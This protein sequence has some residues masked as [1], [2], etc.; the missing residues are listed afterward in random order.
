MSEKKEPKDGLSNVSQKELLTLMNSSEYAMFIAKSGS[1]MELIY[2]NDKF[3]SM[4]QYT[5]DEYIEK[6]GNSLMATVLDEE[7]Q[8]LR[9]LIARQAAAGGSLKLEYRAVRKDG[10]IAWLSLS[11]KA[12]V[13][14]NNFIYYSSCLD[15]TKSKKT[16]DDIYN[17]KREIDVMANSIPGGVIKV[18]MS[19]FKI[20]YAN[21]G[22]FILSG[23]SRSE[24]QMEFGGYY[25]SILY[26]ADIELVKKY[27]KLA[28][29]NH[30]LLGF[31]CR[32]SIKNGEVKWVYVNGR[33]ID[34]DNGQPVYL[35]ILTDITAKKNIEAEFNDNVKRAEVI[36]GF[37][38]AIIWT[39]DIAS[40][41]IKQ[42]GKLEPTYP[43]EHHMNNFN[44]VR[45]IMKMMHPNDIKKFKYNLK[46]LKEREWQTQEVYLIKNNT[47]VFQN[48]EIS[49]ISL[50]DG[51]PKP[52][53]I[54]GMIR[55]KNANETGANAAI[56]ETK[57]D[58]RLITLAK[59]SKSKAE[60]YITGLMPYSSFLTK[61]DKVLKCRNEKDQYAIVCA[62]IN[63]FLKF[64]HHYGFSVSNQIL[65]AFSK[66]IMGTIAKNGICSRVDGDYFVV[67]FKYNQHKELMKIMSSMVRAKEEFDKADG[68]VRFGTTTGIYL[69]QP[70]DDEL[71]DM[72]GKADLARRSIK[73]LMGDHY[74]IYTE[75][76][77][78]YKFKED[79][80]IDEI[81]NA[82][83]TRNIEICFI[84]RIY[85][86]KENI[87]GCK[88]IPRVLLKDGQYIESVR[89]LKF[90]ERGG[91]LNEF[92]FVTLFSVCANMGAW[93]M[94]GHKI[95][96]LSIEITASELSMQNA[97]DIIDEIVIRKNH[98][99]PNQIIF[100]IHERY[101]AEGTTIFDMNIKALC[102]KGYQ[103]VISRFGSDHT[104]VDTIRRLPV[105]GIKFHGGY[106]NEHMNNHREKIMFKKIT[107]MAKELGLSVTCGGIQTKMQET[108]A[109]EIGCDVFEG[110]MYYGKVR[111]DVF[112]KIFLTS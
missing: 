21:D 14:E 90:I 105:T 11:A 50:C 9:N 6:F 49:A 33:R 3:Y 112:E 96:P 93:K 48:M 60:D 82:M 92:A 24:F 73:G 29:E 84:P 68:N 31:E 15:I 1:K 97:V 57:N 52:S 41:N 27:I 19:D 61:V 4:L 43:Q 2:A 67:M 64:S 22:F 10:S 85:K 40:N 13:S 94:Q 76:L 46:Q 8:K 55:L 26:P 7:K 79:E 59:T 104:A 25:D 110:D 69:V 35:C 74:A 86:T 108:F 103:V 111:Y 34:D 5:H 54:Y 72:L 18:R 45:Y 20:I 32:L 12:V 87:T 38:N 23:Y 89:L 28:I 83:R 62:D 81:Y 98:L 36:A 75:D 99:E 71:A 44:E 42:S 106:F 102:Q 39:Y 51:S 100:E 109:K 101:F 53:K 66:I 56:E 77:Q 88:A 70:E 78:N 30:G 107:E 63:E 37:L 16:L 91:K 17:A 80:I 47:G 65:K 95:V 58:N